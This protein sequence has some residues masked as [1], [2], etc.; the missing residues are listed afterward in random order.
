MRKALTGII[1]SNKMKDTVTV[2]VE[3]IVQ[4]P[5][6]LKRFKRHEK[7]KAHTKESFSIGD[8]VQIEECTPVSKDKKWKVIKLV[9]KAKAV[10]EAQDL[11]VAEIEPETA[12]EK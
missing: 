10:E 4:H 12:K 2:Q 11:D 3:R 5:K 6:Y 7:Y 8:K 9:A 1:T